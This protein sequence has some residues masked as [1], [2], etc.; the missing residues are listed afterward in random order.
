MECVDNCKEKNYYILEYDSKLICNESCK[1][2]KEYRNN[3][4]Y[5]VSSCS[6]GYGY[7]NREVIDENNC[8][9]CT[10]IDKNMIVNNSVCV[11]NSS[12]SIY[13]NTENFNLQNNAQGQ[14]LLSVVGNL[15]QESNY[16]N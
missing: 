4:I 13:N 12:Y 9:N 5:C 10:D 15:Y 7:D 14:D 6:D 3:D 16:M 2:K 1:N 11:C 8:Y